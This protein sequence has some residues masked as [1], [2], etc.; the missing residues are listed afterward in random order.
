MYNPHQM[1]SETLSKGNNSEIIIHFFKNFCKSFNKKDKNKIFVII[2]FKLFI[3]DEN[4]CSE[5]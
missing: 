1:W 5:L 3:K 4:V 2:I